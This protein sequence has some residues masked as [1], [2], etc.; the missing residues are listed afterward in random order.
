MKSGFNP[1]V[2]SILNSNHIL[3][4]C[5]YLAHAHLLP[6]VPSRIQGLGSG[7]C[8]R[9]SRRPR[10]EAGRRGACT[11]PGLIAGGAGSKTGRRGALAVP[12]PAGR[13]PSVDL[14]ELLQECG[15]GGEKEHAGAALI[16]TLNK[17]N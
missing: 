8:Q 10:D 9:A 17:K 15:G 2:H 7:F 1:T 6:A 5:I 16:G 4:L 12:V 13:G 14:S 11:F 3:S